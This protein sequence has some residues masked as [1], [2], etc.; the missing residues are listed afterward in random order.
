MNRFDRQ[1]RRDQK[2]RDRK[3]SAP[4]KTAVLL[5]CGLL[6][7]AGL[8]YFGYLGLSETIRRADE[9]VEAPEPENAFSLATPD[10]DA[11]IFENLRYLDRDGQIHYG[12][13]S[14]Q[15]V[16]DSEASA[17]DE[18][19][20]FFYRYLHSIIMGD[21]ATY[22]GCFTESYVKTTAL[23]ERFTMQM[24]YDVEVQE[25]GDLFGEDTA[26]ETVIGKEFLVSYR[27][28]DNNGTFRD[29][30]P[31]RASRKEHY[32]VLMTADGTLKIDA[33]VLEKDA[34]I[35][36]RRGLEPGRAIVFGLIVFL[37]VLAPILALIR[38]LR[39]LKRRKSKTV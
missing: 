35:L 33:I 32:K 13:L 4:V 18:Y 25:I 27:I 1:V 9:M 7:W 31:P 3:N 21:A 12:T 26:Q 37:C 20:A 29:D 11:N 38:L 17:P 10:Y 36:V 14:N 39:Y 22:R 30:L 6:L 16:L 15:V 24:L 2:A 5:L 19:G 28:L 34:A 23:P 8:S